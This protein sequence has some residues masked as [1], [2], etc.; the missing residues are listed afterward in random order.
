MNIAILGTGMVG[1]ALAGRLHELGNNVTI[2]TRNVAATKERVGDTLN[3]DIALATFADAAAGAEIIFLAVKGAVAIETL[4][5]AGA[6]NLDGKIVVDINNPLDFSNGFP[7]TLFVKDTESLGEQIQ[8]AFPKARIVK[9]LNTLAADLMVNPKQINN[10]NHTVFVSG[11]D[12][13]AK[14]N[15]VEIL[16][17]F[18]HTDIIDL[19]DITTARGTEMMMPVWMRLMGVLGTHM[20]QF[21]VVR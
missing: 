1:Q 16:E 10:G 20:F 11:N 4:E 2:G 19:G 12:A 15:V 14:T 3:P 5:L 13:E 21:K 8:S 9:S 17:S 6:E 7:A 18:G